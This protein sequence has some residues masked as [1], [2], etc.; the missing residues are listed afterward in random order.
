MISQVLGCMHLPLVL[1]GRMSRHL[2]ICVSILNLLKL[3]NINVLLDNCI[4]TLITPVANATH[5]A[6][7]TD[8]LMMTRKRNVV[9]DDVRAL[10]GQ[11]RSDQTEC[12]ASRI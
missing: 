7:E 3:C 4:G 11:Q 1:C 10:I 6:I 9:E 12:A 2:P 8:V 5:T